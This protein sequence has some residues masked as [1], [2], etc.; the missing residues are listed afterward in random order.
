MDR[1]DALEL[2]DRRHPFSWLELRRPRREP[3]YR[4]PELWATGVVH[5]FMRRLLQVV[6]ERL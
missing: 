5:M 1:S 2:F 6:N 4:Q 3:T